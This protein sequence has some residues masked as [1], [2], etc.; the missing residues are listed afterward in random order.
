[1]GEG[2]TGLRT[3][4]GIYAGLRNGEAHAVILRYGT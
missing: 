3:I 2:V 4:C 1:M